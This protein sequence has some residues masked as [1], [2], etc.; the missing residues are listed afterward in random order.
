MKSVSAGFATRLGL[1]SM[2][3]VTCV[4]LKATDGTILGLTDHNQPLPID[5]SDGD[6]SL[7]YK[8]STGHLRTAIKTSAGLAVDNLDFESF[9]DVTAITKADLRAGVWDHAEAWMFEVFWDDLALGVMKLRRGRLGEVIATDNTFTAELRG[10]AQQYSQA[11][12]DLYKPKCPVDLGSSPGCGVRLNPPAWAATT[13]YTVRE[14]RDASTGSVVKPLAAANDRH[15]KCTTA[16][17]SGASEPTWNTTVG[18]TTSDGT[19]VWEAIR[20]LTVSTTIDVVTNNKLFTLNYTG[21]APDA[22][23]TKGLAIFTSGLNSGLKQEVKIWDLS[24]VKVELFLAMPF[25]VVAGDGITLQA[26]CDKTL[27]TCKATFDNVENFRGFPHI[28]GNDLLFKT[29]NARP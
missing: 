21:D 28:P 6:G 7:S 13:A 14:A 3:L 22:L 17:I 1:R 27:A 11:I 24:L 18:G 10:M 26:G 9:F 8:A 29:P 12:V 15:F 5:L 4:K 25:D 20:A 2:K 16:G 23:H 19:V